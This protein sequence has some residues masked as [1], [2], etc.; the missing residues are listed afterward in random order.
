MKT[1]L[2]DKNGNIIFGLESSNS[3]SDSSVEQKIT[4]IE[5]H[6]GIHIPSQF[7]QALLKYNDELIHVYGH[8]MNCIPLNGDVS[9]WRMFDEASNKKYL[10]R[11]KDIAYKD[12]IV[13]ESMGNG[14]SL[15]VYKNNELYFYSHDTNTP[16]TKVTIY[17]DFND[18]LNKALKPY[19]GKKDSSYTDLYNKNAKIVDDVC[20]KYIVEDKRG[21]ESLDLTKIEYKTDHDAYGVN[22][23]KE[24]VNFL[25]KNKDNLKK[26]FLEAM[27]NYYKESTYGDFAEEELGK[28]IKDCTVV[29]MDSLIHGP[30]KILEDSSIRS[31]RKSDFVIT[32]ENKL[33]PEHGIAVGFSKSPLKVVETGDI[34]YFL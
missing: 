21:A 4:S 22:V 1:V 11:I 10:T 12:F 18:Y 34:G 24:T 31:Y 23:S 5:K 20:K 16:L 6:Y 25:S 30:Y 7:R 13:V 9:K 2:Y 19:F 15:L 29:D 26:M 28:K 32:A 27:L 17:K 3:V 8:D 14:D 33:D